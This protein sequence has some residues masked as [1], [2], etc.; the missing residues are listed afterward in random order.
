MKSL[1]L[2]ISLLAG[3]NVHAS[4]S[5]NYSLPIIGVKTEENF[6]LN[7]IQ[8]RTEYRD[9]VIAK[10]CWRRVADGYRTVCRQVEEQRCYEDSESRRICKPVYVNR[11][12]NEVVYRDEA[13]TCYETVRRGYEVFSHNTKANVNV[14]VSNVPGIQAPHNTCGIDF[15]LYGGSFSSVAKCSEFIVLATT[16]SASESRVGDTVVQNRALDVTLL[17]AKKI[18]APTRNGI[19]EMRLEGQTLVLR[20][21]DLSKNSNFTL[22]LFAKRNKLLG[23]DT[24]L[25]E[26]NLAPAEYSFEKISEDAGLVKIDLKKLVGGVDRK[27]KHNIK[28][29][30][31]VVVDLA[32]A[33]NAS[34][35]KLSASEEIVVN[36]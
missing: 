9:E 10:T 28:V 4:T 21:G 33:I 17:D 26:R 11:C 22:K 31:N 7:A 20:T 36:D 30:I 15:T 13:Y 19:Q 1:I 18:S 29:S 24:V 5:D 8:T 16:K 23:K 25:I 34:L 2:A 35:P 6:S 3:L 12:H 32:N 27:K 14:K